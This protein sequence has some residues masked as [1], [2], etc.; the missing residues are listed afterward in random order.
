MLPCGLY[1]VGLGEITVDADHH[2][3]HKKIVP[4]LY[5]YEFG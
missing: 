2:D 3:H 5:K 4:G 1:T